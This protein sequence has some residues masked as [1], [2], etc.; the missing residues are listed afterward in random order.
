MIFRFV[1]HA[2][3]YKVREV[4]LYIVVMKPGPLIYLLPLF[5]S[6]F[7]LARFK[8]VG[9][10]FVRTVLASVASSARLTNVGTA[11]FPSS[12]VL[13]RM[14]HLRSVSPTCAHLSRPFCV[15]I[16][17]RVH[18]FSLLYIGFVLSFCFTLWSVPQRF[19][20]LPQWQNALNCWPSIYRLFSS[21]FL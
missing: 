20:A 7:L 19:V 6:L 11:F 12:A 1:S 15:F 21:P 14:R 5:F 13:C 3:F 10:M 9:Q 2:L 18:P 16:C 4:S 17:M 8:T